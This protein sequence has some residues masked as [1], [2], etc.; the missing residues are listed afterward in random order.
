ML[1]KGH[2][3]RKLTDEP[4]SQAGSLDPELSP[5]RSLHFTLEDW[6]PRSTLDSELCPCVFWK[7]PTIQTKRMTKPSDQKANHKHAVHFK[8]SKQNYWILT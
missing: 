2:I 4:D 1:S 7:I 5:Q 6:G 8:G 3:T